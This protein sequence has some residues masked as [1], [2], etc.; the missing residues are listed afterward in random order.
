MRFSDIFQ[1][2]QSSPV[3][4]ERFAS[5]LRIAETKLVGPFLT[6]A[7]LTIAD[8]IAMAL[9]EFADQFYG[10]AVPSDCHELVQWYSR[11]STRAS[12]RPPK[13]PPEMLALSRGLPEQTRIFI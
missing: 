9:L 10:V 12:T 5:K 11:L 4:A 1:G 7:K 6:G 3:G 8:C 2:R 13:Y